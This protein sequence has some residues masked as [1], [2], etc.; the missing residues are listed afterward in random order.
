MFCT[1]FLAIE[2]DRAIHELGYLEKKFTLSYILNN[3]A[4]L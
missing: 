4:L 3:L 2:N 1:R